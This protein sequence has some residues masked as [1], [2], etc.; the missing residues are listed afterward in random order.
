MSRLWTILSIL[1]VAGFLCLETRQGQAQ[2]LQ[3]QPQA[4]SDINGMDHST[5]NHGVL[6]HIAHRTGDERWQVAASEEVRASDVDVTGMDHSK[7][8]HG[9]RGAARVAASS[10]DVP[11]KVA[12]NVV[13]PASQ[14]PPLSS[15]APPAEIAATAALVQQRSAAQDQ[16]VW[17]PPEEIAPRVRLGMN[18][19]A[20]PRSE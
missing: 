16:L 15:W 9:V 2:S 14:I 6:G 18:A 8:N 5:L 7:L 17:L 1:A 12:L 19:D 10:L 3:G 11:A 20:R 13:A 4:Q